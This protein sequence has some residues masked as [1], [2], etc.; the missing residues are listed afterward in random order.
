MLDRQLVKWRL[1]RL[2]NTTA[3][4]WVLCLPLFCRKFCQESIN[5]N[6]KC[7]VQSGITNSHQATTY[8]QLV[9]KIS[10]CD[11]CFDLHWVEYSGIQSDISSSKMPLS[12][13]LANFAAVFPS[14]SETIKLWARS[15]GLLRTRVSVDVSG[16]QTCSVLSKGSRS[17]LS[18]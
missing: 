9:G 14:F 17:A 3:R 12:E 13:H 1:Q 2:L 4:F 6:Q 18:L 15:Q 5:Q 16:I 11:K 10:I 7:W 8:Q